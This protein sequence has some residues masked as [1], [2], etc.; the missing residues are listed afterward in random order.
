MCSAGSR[1]L[2]LKYATA[3]ALAIK[4]PGSFRAPL[5]IGANLIFMVYL[6]WRTAKV[7]GERYS[8]AG[9]A[10]YYRGVWNLFYAQY[11]VFPF[12]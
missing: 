11:A 10:G 3:I 6:A 8:Q 4:M 2:A 1:L 7:D 5:M 9:I 12:I